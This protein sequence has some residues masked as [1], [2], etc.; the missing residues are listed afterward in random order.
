ME[1]RRRKGIGGNENGKGIEER[2]RK[3][4]RRKE[5]GMRMKGK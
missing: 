3:E 5:N 1:G 2:K 4:F